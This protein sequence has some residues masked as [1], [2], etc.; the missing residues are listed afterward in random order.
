[1]VYYQY[2]IGDTVRIPH[3]DTPRV[4]TSIPQSTIV[5]QM[6]TQGTIPNS[7]LR[8]DGLYTQDNGIHTCTCSTQGI[9]VVGRV[10]QSSTEMYSQDNHQHT[11]QISYAY[12]VCN[13]YAY[14]VYSM[15][16]IV[17]HQGVLQA[18]HH[19]QQYQ[20]QASPPWYTR[21]VL[22]P[23][24]RLRDSQHSIPTPVTIPPLTAT[25]QRMCTQQYTKYH[26]QHA[27]PDSTM[28]YDVHTARIMVYQQYIIVHT[29]TQ[30][31]QTPPR[32]THPKYRCSAQPNTYTKYTPRVLSQTP[33][34][35]MMDSTL[36]IMVYIRIRIVYGCYGGALLD[37]N[38]TLGNTLGNTTT[39]SQ[40]ISYVWQCITDTHTRYVL[41][42]PCF[43]P[44]QHSMHYGTHSTPSSRLPIV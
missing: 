8:Y 17:I 32:C 39:P 25:H 22:I 19:H 31:H 43:R 42:Y 37:T 9:R 36:G 12:V 38:S 10:A 34:Q 18:P 30:H 44:V 3:T 4:A 21:D 33:P 23:Q 6:H 40:E 41:W 27:I 20:Q 26:T 28:G 2:L 16:S 14:Y 5:H 7:T 15:M 35:H 13:R 29:T 24:R 1:M 11:Y